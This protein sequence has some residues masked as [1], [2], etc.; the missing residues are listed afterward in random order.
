[1]Q[2]L[3]KGSK[4]NCRAVSLTP[5]S[6]PVRLCCMDSTAAR[7]SM[8]ILQY[9]LQPQDSADDE[10]TQTHLDIPSFFFSIL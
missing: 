1:M 10:V 9:H 4:V 2:H 5:L 3:R 6:V 8:H 7:S